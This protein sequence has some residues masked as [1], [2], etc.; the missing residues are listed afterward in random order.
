MEKASCHSFSSVVLKLAPE[1]NL[2]K[3]QTKVEKEK[4]D[5]IQKRATVKQTNEHFKEGLALT[6][7]AEAESIQSYTL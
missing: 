7:L 3:N 5:R 2:A 4:H 6:F 1:E